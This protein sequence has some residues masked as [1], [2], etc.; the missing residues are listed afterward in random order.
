MA[1]ICRTKRYIDNQARA[2]EST[3]GLLRCQMLNDMPI[4]MQTSK[5]KPEI[6][7]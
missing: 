5:S 3:K 1:N 7:F 2:L 4:M 6:E